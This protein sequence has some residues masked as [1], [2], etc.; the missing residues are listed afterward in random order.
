MTLADQI[1]IY[2]K[3]FVFR[4]DVYAEYWESDS[5]RGYSPA[6]GK[7]FGE[8]CV[9]RKGGN[10][11][12]CIN[13]DFLPVTDRVI[14]KHLMGTQ[15]CGFYPLFQDGTIQFIAFD[16]DSLEQEEPEL[17]IEN[18]DCPYLL[19]SSSSKGYHIYLLFSEKIQA[20]RIVPYY[21]NLIKK[22]D[23]KIEIFP[24]QDKADYLGSLIRL[25][26]IL[27]FMGKGKSCILDDDFS[28][29]T[30]SWEYLIT[31]D[32]RI[33]PEQ[34]RFQTI[35]PK[36]E[37]GKKGS[38]SKQEKSGRD[39]K[40]PK[41]GD[42][43]KII[44]NC[45]AV[46]RIVDAS[47]EMTHEQ[48]VV[49]LSF[50]LNTQNG[51]ACLYQLI[52]ENSDFGSETGI[53]KMSAQV[54]YAKNRGEKPWSCRALMKKGYCTKGDKEFCMEQRGNVSPSPIRFAFLKKPP[55]S[56]DQVKMTQVSFGKDE[57]VFELEIR[58]EP[59]GRFIFR[60]FNRARGSWRGTLLFFNRAGELIHEDSLS[61]NSSSSRK[62]F[63]NTLDKKDYN[64]PLDKL[65]YRMGLK[66]EQNYRDLEIEKKDKIKIL[67]EE[68]RDKAIVLLRDKPLYRIIQAT[69]RAGIVGEE[70][71]RLI[72][73]LTFLSRILPSP[74][75]LLVKG[76]SSSGK[77]A[78]CQAVSILV[79]PEGFKFI[80]RAT[81]QSFF[82]LEEDGMTH[83]IFYINEIVGG[84]AASYSIRSAQSEGSLVLQVTTRNP[85]TGEFETKSKTVKGP[86]GFLTT[87]TRSS[88]GLENET[89]NFSVYTDSSSQQTNRIIDR[90]AQEAEG[91]E[92]A[93]TE[94]QIERIR[95]MQRALEVYPVVIPYAKSVFDHFPRD[96]LRVRRD[97]DQFRRLMEV[98]TIMHQYQREFKKQNG[99]KVLVSNL[100]DYY[101]VSRIARR[102]VT[103]SIFGLNPN[104]E[105]VLRVAETFG[106]ER[107]FSSKDIS[108]K[109]DLSLKVIK[110]T[111]G[112]L[113]NNYYLQQMGDD[114][115]KI[116]NP[117]QEFLPDMEDLD[118]KFACDPSL[119]YDPFTGEQPRFSRK[120][121]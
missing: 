100:A 16:F 77:S 48:R 67:S 96:A 24:K 71:I 103:C 76:P 56:T 94:V 61:L 29:V 73:Y 87:T 21:R 58:G 119:I 72:V 19:T 49:L 90:I 17:L 31:R 34:I 81:A 64:L 11:S 117:I 45:E 42:Y 85:A 75:N 91:Q 2:Q 79:P 63:Q 6:C 10:C 14:E 53:E 22:L 95:D 105:E 74:L 55:I 109:A 4:Q 50:A 118:P 115:Y 13:K 15:I 8:E 43:R 52:A 41:E 106:D 59:S 3:Y 23:L 99:K 70:E 111:I 44:D 38:V 92:F 97:I 40:P 108:K 57:I 60:G 39:W 107:P 37:P 28:P 80:T 47:D 69:D 30:D 82:H 62:R 93:L 1:E 101:I 35:K 112:W 20:S 65:T 78:T 104:A 12:I 36:K 86:C 89:R 5:S 7:K 54:R 116:L 18:L 27:P 120:G 113:S 102:V 68:E 66:L 121:F 84:E 98:I 46:S 51:L 9:L 110:G 114:L 25:P 26:L 88:I 32:I 83:K 33:P